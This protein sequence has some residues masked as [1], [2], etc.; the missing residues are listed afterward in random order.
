[1]A[2]S[3]ARTEAWHAIGESAGD[4]LRATD[5][6]LADLQRQLQDGLDQ[7]QALAVEMEDTESDEDSS[8]GATPET[9]SRA[10]LLKLVQQNKARSRRQRAASKTNQRLLAEM[11]ELRSEIS[12]RE[13]VCDTR[14]E[15]RG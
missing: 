12:R 15:C 9:P 6:V 11:A 7:Q 4:R 8:P 3:R 14:L 5:P 10:Y 13:A 1:M 2:A